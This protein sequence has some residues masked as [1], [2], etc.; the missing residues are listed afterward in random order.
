MT[1][2]MLSYTPRNLLAFEPQAHVS[3]RC[4]RE[5]FLLFFGFAITTYRAILIPALVPFHRTPQGPTDRQTKL[6]VP[7]SDG[8]L[9]KYD[10]EWVV[11]LKVPVCMWTSNRRSSRL[12]LQQY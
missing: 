2:K 8:H 12:Y 10:R 4:L 9:T 1:G 3:Y 11:T 5:V 6:A 7:E